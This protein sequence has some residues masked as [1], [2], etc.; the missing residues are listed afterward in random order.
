MTFKVVYKKLYNGMLRIKYG[1]TIFNQANI[2]N[3]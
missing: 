1:S 3:G 2:E